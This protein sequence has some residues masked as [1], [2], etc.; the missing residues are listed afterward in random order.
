MIQIAGE[1]WLVRLNVRPK[2]E[3]MRCENQSNRTTRNDEPTPSAG[4]PDLHATPSS[5]R[6]RRSPNPALFV[7]HSWRPFPLALLAYPP[8]PPPSTRSSRSP[9]S[10]PA[11]PPFIQFPAKHFTRLNTRRRCS[12][13]HPT[14][15]ALLSPSYLAH[16]HL[17]SASL[18]PASH[19]YPPEPQLQLLFC[20]SGVH[21]ETPLH[22]FLL[23]PRTAFLHLSPPL[24]GPPLPS[25]LSFHCHRR[26][27]SA[28]TTAARPEAA[29][30]TPTLRSKSVDK[31]PNQFEASIGISSCSYG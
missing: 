9:L 16:L 26:A 19:L 27:C 14:L 12:C 29:A 15:A 3:Q 23:S 18:Y 22:L 31:V 30:V 11:H 28:A 20:S 2:A 10:R 21:C 25:Y 13:S 17:R 5:G 8:P 24:I 4:F 7:F 1:G 6:P